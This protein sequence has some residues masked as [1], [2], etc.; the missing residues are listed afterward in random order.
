MGKKKELY[1]LTKT[2]H[3]EIEMKRKIVKVQMNNSEVKL[4]MDT[5]SDVTLMNKQIR[6][7]ISKPMQLKTKKIGQHSTS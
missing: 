4:Q 7:K 3:K 5:G 6:K 2:E 1:K